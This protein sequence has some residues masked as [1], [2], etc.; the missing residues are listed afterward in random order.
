M[1]LTALSIALVAAI[2]MSAGCSTQTVSHASKP[3]AMSTDAEA[4]Y[5][6]GR[7]Y[8]GQQ[9]YEL[10][11]AAYR[12]AL[13]TNPAHA[14]AHNGL[15]A[16]LLLSGKNAEA[17]EQFKAGLSHDPRSAALWNNL[18][19][20]Y[21]LSGEKQLAEIAYKNSLDIDPGDTKTNTN[22]AMVK[23]PESEARPVAETTT[24]AAKPEAAPAIET[25]RNEVTQAT[26]VV[27]AQAGGTSAEPVHPTLSEATPVAPPSTPAPLA[28]VVPNEPA[29]QDH[30]AP[31]LAEKPSAV[32]P[33]IAQ[34]TTAAPAVK[35]QPSLVL[36]GAGAATEA[37][38][39]QVEKVAPRVYEVNLA[40]KAAPV[41]AGAA[42]TR[43]PVYGAKHVSVPI[44]E[45]EIKMAS[46]SPDDFSI[47]IRNGN[48]VRR[49]A[50]R[51]SQYLAGLGY[52]TKRLT[53]ERGFNVK[54][55]QIFYLPG[56]LAQAE[57]LREHM[58]RDTVL[59]ESTDLRRGTHVRV[60]LGR[61]LI[62]QQAGLDAAPRN[63]QLAAL[64]Y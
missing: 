35:L 22:L 1:K 47:E 6:L 40:E 23:Q 27:V 13:A 58:P 29:A 20:A 64:Q 52:T 10:A 21:A 39:V 5:A 3:T 49:L 61:D 42:T 53:N 30:A 55:T 7:Y 14:G 50:W 51:T 59:T 31:V 34:P 54:V 32:Q 19:Y 36:A 46:V 56:Y 44:Q 45:A 11:I 33:V 15:G 16:S 17:V 37:N 24:L 63:I 12:L 9:R 2:G 43:I 28:A 18:G 41:V 62:E 60:V 26:P 4:Q 25:P 48:G 8:Q 38:T 57:K